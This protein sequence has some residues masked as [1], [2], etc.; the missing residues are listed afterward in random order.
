MAETPAGGS[1]D[2]KKLVIIGDGSTRQVRISLSLGCDVMITVLYRGGPENEVYHE[3]EWST[4]EERKAKH[5][6][7]RSV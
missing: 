4:Y 7:R 3:S 2:A 1:Q 5:R 6:V